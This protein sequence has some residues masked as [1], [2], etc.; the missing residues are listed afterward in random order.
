MHDNFFNFRNPTPFGERDPLLN[1]TW[2]KSNEN[3]LFL[4]IGRNLTVGPRPI[5]ERVNKFELAGLG[6]SPILNDC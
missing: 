6:D 1:V 2:P 3:G 5:N 4:D